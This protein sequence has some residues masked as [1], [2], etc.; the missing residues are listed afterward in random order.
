MLGCGCWPGGKVVVAHD[1]E[2]W[3]ALNRMQGMLALCALLGKG[4]RWARGDE[5]RAESGRST[6]IRG[7]RLEGWLAG[8][9]FHAPRD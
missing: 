2:C 1:L 6:Q 8:G 9:W 4:A 7:F 5:G 3:R